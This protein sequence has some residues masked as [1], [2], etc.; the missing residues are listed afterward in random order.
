[1]AKLLLILGALPNI[2]KF[3]TVCEKILE[4]IKNMKHQWD[5]I[6]FQKALYRAS[7]AAN[8]EGD[9]SKYEELIKGGKKA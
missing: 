7:E 9:T 5:I 4:V 6:E 1:M 3:W 2:L 8:K